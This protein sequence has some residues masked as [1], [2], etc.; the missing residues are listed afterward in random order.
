VPLVR[1]ILDKAGHEQ[2]FSLK[3]TLNG[4]CIFQDGKA[5]EEGAQRP[6]HL[7]IGIEHHGAI[8]LSSQTNR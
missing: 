6:L 5:L 1:P 2:P 8:R 7:F 4:P 3:G